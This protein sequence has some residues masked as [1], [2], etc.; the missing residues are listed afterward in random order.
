MACPCFYPVEPLV[1]AGRRP[2]LAPLG[3]L[4][5]GMC[6]A[7]DAEWR[8]N[9]DTLQRQCN[10]GYARTKCARCPAGGPD[11]VRF[12]I[13]SDQG[14]AIGVHW[15]VEKDHMPFAHGRLEYSRADAGFETA[16]PDARIAQQAQAYVHSYLRRTENGH[17]RD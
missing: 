8:P 2:T 16:H 5:S 10:F 12:C 1:V 13:S 7:A 6:H 4:W 17:E 3:D 9:S 15:V 11:A 14:G